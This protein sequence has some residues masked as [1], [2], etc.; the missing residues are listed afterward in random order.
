MPQQALGDLVLGLC[1]ARAWGDND[2]SG[3]DMD[4][5]WLGGHMVKHSE[6]D[7]HRIC[8]WGQL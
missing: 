7:P 3:G 4:S 5:P 2:G 1:K 8:P 6:W